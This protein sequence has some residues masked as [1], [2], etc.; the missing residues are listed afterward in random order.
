MPAN[1]NDIT[2][3]WRTAGPKQWF[4]KSDRF[5][6][7]IR[8]KYEPVHHAATRARLRALGSVAKAWAEPR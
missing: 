6:D 5:D 8:L 3:F 2:Q 7:A 1:L 4:A